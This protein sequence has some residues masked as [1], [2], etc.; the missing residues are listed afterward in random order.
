[1]IYTLLYFKKIKKYFREFK[2]LVRLKR[3]LLNFVY[4][5]NKNL[6]K[7]IYTKFLFIIITQEIEIRKVRFY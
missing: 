2:F 4:L 3:L 7:L 5:L 6:S 1:M